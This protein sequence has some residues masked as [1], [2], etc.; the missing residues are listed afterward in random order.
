MEKRFCS[1]NKFTI[2]DYVEVLTPSNHFDKRR[3]K[4]II[5]KT[6]YVN[7]ICGSY[8]VYLNENSNTPTRTLGT[9]Y[10]PISLL[11]SVT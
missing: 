2:G 11:K 10:M 6:F 3:Y 7:G 4:N 8:G 1:M 5:G 9:K